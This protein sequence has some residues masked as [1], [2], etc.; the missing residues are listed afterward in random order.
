M[1][2]SSDSRAASAPRTR[3][4]SSASSSEITCGPPT[5]P[6]LRRPTR[7]GPGQRSAPVGCCRRAAEG[8]P[9][10]RTPPDRLRASSSEPPASSTRF[11]RPRSPRPAPACGS[12]SARPMPSSSTSTLFVPTVTVHS[13]AAESAGRRSHSAPRTIQPNSALRCSGTSSRALG[14]TAWIPAAANAVLALT[15]SAARL[16]SRDPLM[17]ARTSANDWRAIR[18]MSAISTADRALSESTSRPASSDFIA[19]TVSEWPRMSCRSRAI[20][21]RSAATASSVISSRAAASCRPRT[22]SLRDACMATLARTTPRAPPGT[23]S[24]DDGNT[25]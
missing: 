20:R 9:R 3:A 15:I 7:L 21:S 25:R 12:G 22:A 5:R 10:S 1:S 13:A 11:C 19:I 6:Q 17:V 8:R 23:A 18:S 14:S 2:S 24:W 16:T 4:W